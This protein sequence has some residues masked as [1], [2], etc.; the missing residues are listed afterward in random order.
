MALFKQPPSVSNSETNQKARI[1]EGF[2]SVNV[3]A[4]FRNAIEL[5]YSSAWV[6]LSS[7]CPTFLLP[8]KFFSFMRF[9]DHGV[10]SREAR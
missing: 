10:E 4:A 5:G 6:G 3:P 2:V 1:R 7:N 8:R 9:G